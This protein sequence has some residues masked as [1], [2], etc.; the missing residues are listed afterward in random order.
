M[1]F[2]QMCSEHAEVLAAREAFEKQLEDQLHMPQVAPPREIKSR[3]FS[4][5]GMEQPPVKPEPGIPLN[6]PVWIQRSGFPRFVSAASL[7]LVLGSI[8]LNLYLLSQY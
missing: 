6:R 8:L 3:I 5:V 4:Q 7:V 2:E 1:E